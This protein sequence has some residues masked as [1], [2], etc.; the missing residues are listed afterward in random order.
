MEIS[1]VKN[2]RAQLWVCHMC[3]D[4]VWRFNIEGGLVS[5]YF[6]QLHIL[7]LVPEC[8]TQKVEGGKLVAPKIDFY[9]FLHAARFWRAP[10]FWDNRWSHT[11]LLAKT[12]FWECS[13][14]AL[15]MHWWKCPPL[16][17]EKKI[18][19]DVQLLNTLIYK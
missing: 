6:K 16:L 13:S 3:A 4:H 9:F 12:Y 8:H 1:E 18:L 17:H 15:K 2:Q 7:G 14:F 5:R 11:K 10:N 19:W